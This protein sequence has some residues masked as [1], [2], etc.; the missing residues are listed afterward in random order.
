MI[1]DLW[2]FIADKHHD[3]EVNR[4]KY[5]EMIALAEQLRDKR[6]EYNI[7]LYRCYTRKIRFHNYLQKAFTS[8]KVDP[9]FSR[10]FRML[11]QEFWWQLMDVGLEKIDEIEEKVN[12]DYLPRAF[13][14]TVKQMEKYPA[15]QKLNFLFRGMLSSE[16]LCHLCSTDKETI[17][18]EEALRD[19]RKVTR[20]KTFAR[21]KWEVKKL[22]TR[23]RSYLK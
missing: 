13:H 11:I 1:R 17:N 5:E 7:R 21:I 6:Q 8:K 12:F 10:E 15:F 19:Y 2:R 3:F 20:L 16:T 14:H 18:K 4:S 23:Y 22:N 9:A